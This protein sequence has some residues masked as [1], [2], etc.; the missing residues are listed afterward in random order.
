MNM[1]RSSP[2]QEEGGDDDAIKREDE[3]M[4]LKLGDSILLRSN[5]DSGQ[6]GLLTAKG[7]L[8]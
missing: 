1:G 8:D 5:S 6:A 2:I 3:S 7:I 4:P